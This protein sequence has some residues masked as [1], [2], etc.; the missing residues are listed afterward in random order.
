MY[1]TKFIHNFVYII[2]NK[3]NHKKYIGTKSSDNMPED[4]IGH[5]YFSSSSDKDFMNEQKEH[6]EHFRYKVLKDFK[7][8]KEAL[9]L[10]C[11]LH[12]RYKVDTNEE[13]YNRAIQTS[14]GYDCHFKHEHWPD[15]VK[16][17]ISRSN[18]G[19]KHSPETIE[20]IKETMKKNGS[21]K[22]EKNPMY[23]KQH[24]EETLA[25]ISSN[26][27][28]AHKKENHPLWGKHLPE[29]TRQKISSANKGKSRINENHK[30]KLRNVNTGSRWMY[31]LELKECHRVIKEKIPEFLEKGYQYGRIREFER[32][33]K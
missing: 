26:P 8:R 22:G 18:K 12:S 13:F 30:E 9:N 3:I 2:F 32:I 14:E 4:V 29:E 10:E 11:E 19:K 5:T 33:K 31:N 7:S 25:K 28:V 6:P 24:S 17:K 27:N 20:K 21:C 23:G 1:D 16:E 15:Y